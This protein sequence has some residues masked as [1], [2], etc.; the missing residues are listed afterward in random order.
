M[1]RVALV[2]G[3]LAVAIVLLKQRSDDA[4]AGAAP[5]VPTVNTAGMPKE[6]RA[7][8]ADRPDPVEMLR[9]RGALPG[10]GAIRKLADK[11][12]GDGSAAQTQMAPFAD[13]GSRRELREVRADIRRD[14]AALNRL[15]A[16]EG[17]ASIA[18]ITK[19]LAEVYSAPVLNAL[20]TDGVR[21]FASR[22]AGRTEVAQ[23]VKILDFEGVFV[24]GARALAQ[25]VYRL[26]LRAPSGRYVARAPATWTVTLAREDGR[27]RFVQGLET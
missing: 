9:R 12:A 13:V 27:W 1:V 15:S 22:Y 2:I 23:K 7:L 4:G 6:I 14:F 16:V 21:D 18:D 26:S 8:V 19:T 10:M 3:V 11:L 25:V 5:A 24:S 17:G 20:G